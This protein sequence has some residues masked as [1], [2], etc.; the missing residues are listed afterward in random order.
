MGEKLKKAA[1][2]RPSYSQMI[3]SRPL[4]TSSHISASL[5]PVGDAFSSANC[6]GCGEE[7]QRWKRDF[8]SAVSSPLSEE[9]TDPDPLR[10]L[11]NAGTVFGPS[12]Q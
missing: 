8:F 12:E 9:P 1:R 4:L 10:E 3:R 6:R 11:S 2:R 7:E 5:M